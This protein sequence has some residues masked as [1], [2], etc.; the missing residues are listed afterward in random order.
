MSRSADCIIAEARSWIGTPYRHQASCQGAGADCLG[1]VRGVWR[2]VI[3]A[4]PEP[5]PPYT[6][7]WSEA[8]G[9]EDLL[10]GAGRWL[11]AKPLGDRAGGDVI[12]FRMRNGAVAKHLGILVQSQPHP[13]FVH[14]YCG[15]GVVESA[16][17]PPWSCRLAACFAFPSSDE[18]ITRSR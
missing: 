1:L 7:D 15:H 12:L 8:G 16:L 3:G 9:R 6:A 5:L 18:S 13:R 14:A 4:E 17:T 2:A 11:V 10:L